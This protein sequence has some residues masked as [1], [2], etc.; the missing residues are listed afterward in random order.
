MVLLFIFLCL[1]GEDEQLHEMI[2]EA[3]NIGAPIHPTMYGIFF[4]DINYGAD[5]GLYAELIK[6]RSFQF[7]QNFAGWV[8]FG[9]VQLMNDGP[10]PNNPHYV[11]LGNPGHQQKHTGLENEGFFGI[12]VQAGSQYRFSVWA[13]CIGSSQRISIELMKSDR[14]DDS[15]AFVIQE[16]VIDSTE[17]KKYEL[18]FTS[19]LTEFHC[20]FR[21]FLQ[22][23]GDLDLC[24]V[25]LFP[26]DTFKGRLNGLRK[27]LAQALYDLKPGVFRFPGGCVVEG[28]N[29]KT[30]Y[31]WKNTV[32]TVENRPVNENLWGY[33]STFRFFPQYYQS[34]GLGF[35]E[36]FQLAEDIGAEPLPVL[37]VDMVCQARNTDDQ[38]LP[39]SMIGQFIQD[40]LDLI[41]FANGDPKSTKWGQIRSEMGHEKPFNLKFLAIGNEQWGVLYPERLERFITAI[42][43]EHPEIK[44]IGSSGPNP[45]DIMFDYLWNEM[46]LLKTDYV[47]EHYYRDEEWF[48]SHADRYDSYDRTGPKVFAGEYA[49]HGTGRKV[50]HF[51]ASLLEAAFMTGLER[52]ADVVHM[53]TYAPLFAH[54]QGWQWRPDL[55]WFDNLRS[56]KTC[57]YYVQQL[58]SVNKGTNVLSLKMN[59]RV[60][61]GKDGQDGLY[62]SSVWD[63][64]LKAFIVKV[65]NTQNV[66]HRISLN[67]KGL[68]KSVKLVNG[69]CTTFHSDD[70]IIENTLDEPY[71]VVPIES[72]ISIDGHVLDTQ[73]KAKTFAVFKFIKVIDEEND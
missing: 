67:F 7:P 3:N 32:G 31:Q 57:S 2:I 58:F 19:E 34:L 63:D 10:F 36:Y 61:C 24:H 22:T 38:Q 14:D 39:L 47:D 1:T 20:H 45:N 6:N 68:E 16:L 40:A 11:R 73:I 30:R 8:T 71:K 69:T 54:V 35:F 55:I 64:K 65:V 56:V 52:N 26:V 18:V 21:L 33:S 42:R 62:A 70:L 28:L 49:C 51:N 4:E 17:W 27:D 29:E 46:K 60:V 43:L 13:R 41:E 50:N 44:I 37:N 23:S 48:L 66:D 72:S 12:G 5:G 9:N 25:S 53:A 59:G 15:Q